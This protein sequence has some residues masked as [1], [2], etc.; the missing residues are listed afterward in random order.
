MAQTQQVGCY[1]INLASRTDRLDH[2]TKEFAKVDLPFTAFTAISSD[3]AR[4]HPVAS[5]LPKRRRGH[6]LPAEIAC[7]ASHFEVWRI[8]ASGKQEYAAVFEDD[9]YLSPET[10]IFLEDIS[11]ADVPDIVKLETYLHFIYLG[12]QRLK[13][14][15]TFQI[16]PLVSMHFGSAAYLIRRSTASK[17]ISLISRFDLP[18]DWALFEG[19]GRVSHLLDVHQA[20]PALAVQGMLV[21]ADDPL[22]SSNIAHG[23]ETAPPN[24]LGRI[25]EQSRLWLSRLRNRVLGEKVLVEFASHDRP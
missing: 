21:N 8:I 7:A 6:W 17:L 22:F 3:E 25:D 23:D 9:V 14:A 18:V 15:N 13:V 16:R 11:G 2:V 24:V 10:K 20:V 5:L 4:F 1:V 19:K 12:R